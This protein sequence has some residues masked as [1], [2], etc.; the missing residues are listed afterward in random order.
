MLKIITFSAET[1]QKYKLDNILN[2]TYTHK[3]II[4]NG[5]DM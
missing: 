1:H 5:D 2:N 4:E 3:K